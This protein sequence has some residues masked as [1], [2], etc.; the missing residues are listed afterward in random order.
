MNKYSNSKIGM[1]QNTDFARQLVS[2][3]GMLFKGRSGS[4]NVSPT[5]I[6]GYIQLE[7]ENCILFFELKNSGPIPDGQRKA[8]EAL[9]DAVTKG[10]VNCAVFYAIHNTPAPNT[11]VAKNAIVKGIYWDGM[12]RKRKANEQLTLYE[13]INLYLKFIKQEERNNAET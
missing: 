10:G 9:C 4:F 7:N 5:D 6:D 1:F 12:W 13:E 8:L 2:F 11:V 3:E